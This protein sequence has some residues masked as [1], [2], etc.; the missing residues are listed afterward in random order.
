[1]ERLRERAPWI[2]LRGYHERESFS[3]RQVH[4]LRMQIRAKPVKTA[5]PALLMLRASGG[6]RNPL[7]SDN[8]LRSVPML[9]ELDRHSLSRL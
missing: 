3:V 2:Y 8:H 6:I 5:N 9:R 7:V 4:G 1:M